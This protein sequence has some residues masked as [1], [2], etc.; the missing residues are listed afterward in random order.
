MEF[1]GGGAWDSAS[2]FFTARPLP[3]AGRHSTCAANVVPKGCRMQM[4]WNPAR[5]RNS[6]STTVD[7]L[8]VNYEEDGRLVVEELDKVVLTKG[9]WATVMFRYRQ[10]DNKLDDYGPDKYV[11]RR[12]QKYEG[13]YRA[14]SKFNISSV[15]QAKKIV[16]TLQMWVKDAE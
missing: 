8:T 14:K 13:E 11:I 12:Y 10:W 16:E 6:M 2:V 15:D 7:E 5:K 1:D 3:C 9:A 4:L